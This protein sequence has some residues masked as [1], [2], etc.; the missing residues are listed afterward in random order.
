MGNDP[1][2]VKKKGKVL[3]WLGQVVGEQEIEREGDTI[4]LNRQRNQTETGYGVHVAYSVKS[5][6][7]IRKVLTLR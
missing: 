6:R 3:F 1:Q 7:K 5:W 2:A 4:P